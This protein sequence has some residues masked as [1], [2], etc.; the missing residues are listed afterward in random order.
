M[1][2][3][4]ANA[5]IDE[6]VERTRRMMASNRENNGTD[7]QFI[8]SLIE[9]FVGESLRHEKGAGARHMALSVYRMATMQE[10]IDELTESVAMRDAALNTLWEIDN[11]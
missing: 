4:A 10:R 7:E 5:A 9:Q 8:E 6:I 3:D 2:F 11:L 1:A